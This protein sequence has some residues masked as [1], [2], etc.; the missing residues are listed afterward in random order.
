MR[1]T[2]AEMPTDVYTNSTSVPVAFVG[3]K[4]SL[5]SSFQRGD[6]VGFSYSWLQNPRRAIKPWT[7]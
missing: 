2:V 7:K 1:R 4:K 3:K 5:K 6:V